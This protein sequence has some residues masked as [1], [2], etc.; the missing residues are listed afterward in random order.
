MC[1]PPNKTTYVHIIK[2]INYQPSKNQWPK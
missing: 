1:I 2:Y